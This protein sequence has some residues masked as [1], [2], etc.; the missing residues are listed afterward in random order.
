M[1]NKNEID[2][3]NNDKDEKKTEYGR[4]Y[5]DMAVW[6]ASYRNPLK[7]STYYVVETSINKMQFTMFNTVH[8]CSQLN[9][10]QWVCLNS[11]LL[12]HSSSAIEINKT[13]EFIFMIDLTF[14]FIW[15]SRVEF[16]KTCCIVHWFYTSTK[17]PNFLLQR[18]S[19]ERFRHFE[20][21]NILKK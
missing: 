10:G 4:A 8:E 7:H 19:V 21:T 16:A 14:S 18:S 17:K 1:Q 12:L 3:I 6:I 5:I 20:N 13:S 15:V 9:H 2:M 11:P